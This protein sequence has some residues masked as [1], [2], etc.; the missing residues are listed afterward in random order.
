MRPQ[1]S[2]AVEGVTDEAVVR[3][4][5]HHVG[6][7]PGKV[8]VQR[9]KGNL[10]QRAD[11]FNHAARFAPWLILVDLDDDAPCAP[12]LCQDWLPHPAPHLCF[13]VAVRALEAWLMAD[14]DVLASYLSV[15]KTRVPTDPEAEA[16][17]KRTLVNL[18]RRSRRPAI[19]MDMVPR[20]GSGRSEGPAYA[21]RIVEF[22][23]H[24]WRPNVAAERAD[25]L[26]RAIACLRRLAGAR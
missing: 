25:S 22:A 3:R 6:A 21:S 18:A 26:R 16:D 9:G 24:H 14:A 20:E 12:P 7:V 10:R 4:V 15:A 19:V 17:P 2:A 1:I 8:Y 5:I 11:G 23:S 13:R